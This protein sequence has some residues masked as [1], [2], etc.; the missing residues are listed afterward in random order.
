MCRLDQIQINC[1][2]VIC[3]Y[4]RVRP[5]LKLDLVS[6]SPSWGF[7]LPRLHEGVDITPCEFEI[8]KPKVKLFGTIVE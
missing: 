6:P 2:F 3:K 1:D 5:G 7:F 8:D 4:Q